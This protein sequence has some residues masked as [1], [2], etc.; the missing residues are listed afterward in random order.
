MAFEEAMKNLDEMQACLNQETAAQLKAYRDKL[1]GFYNAYKAGD[2]D[3]VRSMRM[4]HDLDRLMLK[5]DKLFRC[6]RV[7]QLIK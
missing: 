6:N 3:V 1:E 4:R 7:Q 5:M 2:F